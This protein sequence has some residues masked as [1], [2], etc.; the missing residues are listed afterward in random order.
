MIYKLNKLFETYISF[1]FYF[2]LSNIT[3][4]DN[5]VGK[6]STVYV[7]NGFSN[8]VFSRNKKKKKQSVKWK[9]KFTWQF[10]E[11]VWYHI[12]PND[13]LLD[14][15]I[16]VPKFSLLTFWNMTLDINLNNY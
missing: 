7:I 13:A 6:H 16:S 8:S 3:N 9:K 2:Q 12:I 1:L 4:L 5:K 14:K 10:S 11:L 15:Y